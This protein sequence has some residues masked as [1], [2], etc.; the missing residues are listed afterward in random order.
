MALPRAAA[1]EEA[2]IMTQNHTPTTPA[3]SVSQ[4]AG[5]AT[6]LRRRGPRPV[7]P[8]VEYHRVLQSDKRRIGRGILAI[9]LLL[10]GLFGFGGIIG[11]VGGQIDLHVL[12]RHNV[13]AGGTE[14][15]PIMQLGNALSIAILIPWSM[16]IQRW[17]YGVK[18]SSLNSVASTLRPAIIGRAVMIVFP[19]WAVYMAIF[20]AVSPYQL[21]DWAIS[22]LILLFV[23]TVVV[24]PYQAAGEEYGLRGLVFRVAGSWGRG[25]RTS[26]VLGIT[27]SAIVFAAIHLSTDIWLNAYY[28]ALAVGWAFITWRTGGLETSIVM[29]A[30]NNTLAFLLS[31]TMHTDPVSGGD[32]SAGVGSAVFLLPIALIAIFS[33]VIWIRTRKT[34][35]AR[36]PALEQSG[37]AS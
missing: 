15:T 16:F 30:A 25:P 23:I 2:E 24:T 7:P 3:A 4:S 28:L 12:G 13:I 31:L 11:Y 21:A 32:R 36:T 37:F 14:F 8:G 17:L 9:V 27:V 1:F 33:A 22:D 20:T 19:V 6:Q 29:H 5:S 34:G 26:L 35:P 18:G 10:V